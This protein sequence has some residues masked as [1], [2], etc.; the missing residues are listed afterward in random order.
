M[1]NK[2]L[3]S[4][5][6]LCRLLRKLGVALATPFEGLDPLLGNYPSHHVLQKFRNAPIDV[7]AVGHEI[8]SFFCSCFGVYPRF[9]N[10]P[11]YIHGTPNTTFDHRVGSI[12]LRQAGHMQTDH[13]GFR[14]VV[15]HKRLK[16]EVSVWNRP[17]RLEGVGQYLVSFVFSILKHTEVVKDL[18]P[19]L[20]DIVVNSCVNRNL[21]RC[22]EVGPHLDL[23]NWYL[24]I[25]HCSVLNKIF[26]SNLWNPEIWIPFIIQ[27]KKFLKALVKPLVRP[28]ELLKKMAMFVS[29][30]PDWLE[31]ERSF[32]KW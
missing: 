10:K 2:C 22:L 1:F 8:V 20:T 15:P 17:R 31:C 18:I 9:K 12:I 19:K 26:F 6:I 24:V 27:I 23:D 3:G 4:H 14:L 30:W 32:S 11:D 25:G 5:F 29:D 7:D 16:V 13:S 28:Q 21:R